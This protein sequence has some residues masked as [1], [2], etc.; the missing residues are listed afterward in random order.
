MERFKGKKKQI[1]L[2]H[3]VALLIL[4]SYI[5]PDVLM[6]AKS[7]TTIKTADMKKALERINNEDDGP[8]EKVSESV[9]FYKKHV[10]VH[11][12]EIVS[13]NFDANVRVMPCF[14]DPNQKCV[15]VEVIQDDVGYSGQKKHVNILGKQV[16]SSIRLLLVSANNTS[17]YV[18]IDVAS[19]SGNT[20]NTQNEQPQTAII[21]I[22][23]TETTTTDNPI[24]Y[25][26]PGANKEINVGH[27]VF[28]GVASYNP[29]IID[30][31]LLYT[32][33]SKID[34]HAKSDIKYNTWTN[35]DFHGNIQDGTIE[36]RYEIDVLAEP[37]IKQETDIHMYVGEELTLMENGDKTNYSTYNSTSGAVSYNVGDSTIHPITI[38]A[39]KVGTG[40]F[41]VNGYG[42]QEWGYGYTKTYNITVTE[43]PIIRYTQNTIKILK[44]ETAT[45]VFKP[46]NYKTITLNADNNHALVNNT[47]EGYVK[48]E[49]GNITGLK[50][51]GNTTGK[52][53][54]KAT[55]TDDWGKT[56]EVTYN[57]EVYEP[58]TV[59]SITPL[60]FVQDA[61]EKYWARSKAIKFRVKFNQDINELKESQ[62][63]NYYKG[64]RIDTSKEI[65]KLSNSLYEVTINLK[66]SFT[67]GEDIE[68]IV[69]PG[70]Y[71]PNTI[72]TLQ[73]SAK[74]TYNVDRIQPK[75]DSI[76]ASINNDNPNRVDVAFVV[77]DNYEL[78]EDKNDYTIN[79]ISIMKAELQFY[80]GDNENRTRIEDFTLQNIFKTKDQYVYRA[81]IDF[82]DLNNY[83]S[84]NLYMQLSPAYIVSN[85]ITDIAGNSTQKYSTSFGISDLM[86][87][88]NKEISRKYVNDA[89]VDNDTKKPIIDVEYFNKKYIKEN[90]DK[91]VILTTQFVVEDE[92]ALNL[93]SDSLVYNSNVMA[94]KGEGTAPLVERTE[95]ITNS[96][97]EV[98][99]NSK[100]RVFVVT[101]KIKLEDDFTDWK[102]DLQI[103]SNGACKDVGGNIFETTRLSRFI[104]ES[105]LTVSMD[106]DEF[107]TIGQDVDNSEDITAPVIMAYPR[108]NISELDGKYYVTFTTN[109]VVSDETAIDASSKDIDSSNLKIKLSKDVQNKTRI[110]NVTNENA[111]KE[112][113]YNITTVAEINAE[114][115]EDEALIYGYEIDSN[116]N[117][118]AD[119]AGN[120]FGK[121]T[122]DAV[123]QITKEDLEAFVKIDK[124]RPEIT[125]NNITK[126]IKEDSNGRYAEIVANFT[127]SDNKAM[128]INSQKIMYNRDMMVFKYVY[129]SNY[130][131]KNVI[132]VAPSQVQISEPVWDMEDPKHPCTYTITS[133]ID[134]TDEDIEDENALQYEITI[135]PSYIKDISGNIPNPYILRDSEDYSKYLRQIQIINKE[136]EISEEPD[137]KDEWKQSHSIV[138]DLM[139]SEDENYV[140]E[141]YSYKWVNAENN[142]VVESGSALLGDRITKGRLNGLYNFVYEV[143][144]STFEG[145][146]TGVVGPFKFDNKVS[147]TEKAKLVFKEAGT[148]NNVF[149][150]A[151]IVE[152]ELNKTSLNAFLNN[153]G[154]SIDKVY[155]TTYTNKNIDVSI[156]NGQGTENESGFK[157]AGF[158]VDFN[159]LLKG[160][161]FAVS[162]TLTEDKKY[163]IFI[164]TEDNS[165]NKFYEYYMINKQA[166]DVILTNPQITSKGKKVKAKAIIP[167]ATEEEV[168]KVEYALVKQDVGSTEKINIDDVEWKEDKDVD[169]FENEKGVELEQPT[170][171]QGKYSVLIRT[172]TK[173][174]VQDI[175]Q[176]NAVEL[177]NANAETESGNEG[178]NQGENQGE[179]N[180]GG[181]EGENQG[182]NNQGGNESGNQGE[183]NQGGNETGTENELSEEDKKL[184]EQMEKELA[185]K[186]QQAQQQAQQKTET[187]KEK[188]IETAQETSKKIGEIN[189]AGSECFIVPVIIGLAV[190]AII[191]IKKYRE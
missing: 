7:V 97:N 141:S 127:I 185:E 82:D 131:I 143:N 120:L 184:I 164:V 162:A 4:M 138:I 80:I 8:Q 191:S 186:Q 77:K 28:N 121:V 95:G 105:D 107:T 117:T 144:S 6:V 31:A 76:T 60:D 189:K 179:N 98:L 149:N 3:L 154:I 22:Q 1:I 36:G 49:N 55:I 30:K 134:I 148:N 152:D 110:V 43:R 35:I 94:F 87:N 40:R 102:Y 168:D 91:Y 67:F 19:E 50:I 79:D 17:D 151:D 133:R 118:C 27:N 132:A 92:N 70:M 190:I 74:F 147:E 11:V 10:T 52:T 137:A 53:T 15:G 129:D 34:I 135:N 81:S 58:L 130:D 169:E 167:N 25:I 54:I 32:N 41:E 178:E 75:V 126:E 153:A 2:G 174:G 9:S 123:L 163:G 46:A 172:T 188:A 173:Q 88:S 84:Q 45:A 125:M 111:T 155:K 83:E 71:I 64:S 69:C 101:S 24:I 142:K 85:K 65:K 182:E 86:N 48:D 116:N 90:G 100:I 5:L 159:G 104:E 14:A 157:Q 156:I 72:I 78:A 39:D 61:E 140:D 112:R 96:V 160:E 181:N 106:D 23:T 124:V 26:K 68:F 59:A 29:Y 99:K 139:D 136:V 114:M 38:K 93:D 119:T 33:A 18:D 158:V 20:D 108:K 57:V 177:K 21:T 166:P 165:G 44:G 115:L 176:S 63:L 12:G 122:A 187:E 161:N 66:D 89:E 73:D 42:N 37:I 150:E 170:D 175:T 16:G 62:I 113:V 183:N 13:V 103:Q 47:D 180:Q 109:V 171:G 128:D 146:I 56:A 51:T 145:K